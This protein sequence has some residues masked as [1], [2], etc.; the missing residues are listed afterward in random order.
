M[1][2][3]A[4]LGN[5]LLSCCVHSRRC[6]GGCPL[7]VPLMFSHHLFAK[8]VKYLAPEAGVA[9]LDE[10]VRH[11]P[12]QRRWPHPPHAPGHRRV[13]GLPVRQRRTHQPTDRRD[14]RTSRVL[15]RRVRTARFLERLPP[16]H[17]GSSARGCAMSTDRKRG[18]CRR[19]E[20][21]TAIPGCSWP[22]DPWVPTS[23]GFHPAMTISALAERTAD[24]V[25][26]SF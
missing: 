15:Q 21:C 26:A 10:S 3:L 24:A 19:P 6:C 11:R 9:A 4:N 22:T 8:P 14:G 17:H 16:H 5:R 25:V 23:I 18:W 20:K 1:T 2:A 12:R 7:A 13:L